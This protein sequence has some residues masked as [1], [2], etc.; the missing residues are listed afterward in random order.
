MIE[1]SRELKVI[2]SYWEAKLVS[3]CSINQG[4]NWK[5]PHAAFYL[6]AKFSMENS[7]TKLSF[8]VTIASSQRKN[9]HHIAQ[10][11]SITLD[12]WLNVV[13]H[14]WFIAVL[15]GSHFLREP[16][17]SILIRDKAGLVWF[18]FFFKFKVLYPGQFLDYH[19]SENCQFWSRLVLT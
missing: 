12:R 15:G 18:F 5:R 8:V 7:K 17:V 10:F 13:L 14:I 3:E 6:L 11:T 16:S 2:W 19:E 4:E 9:N 1:Q